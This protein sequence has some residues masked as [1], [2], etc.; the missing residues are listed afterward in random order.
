MSFFWLREPTFAFVPV[1]ETRVPYATMGPRAICHRHSTTVSDY[2]ANL[3]GPSASI[4]G[5]ELLETRVQIMISWSLRAMFQCASVPVLLALIFSI[6]HWL[7][8]I[9]RSQSQSVRGLA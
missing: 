7:L 6:S 3:Y 1:H 5:V 9:W 8:S 2:F 4:A